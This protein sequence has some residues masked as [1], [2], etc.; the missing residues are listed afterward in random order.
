[1]SLL[2]P[3]A[4]ELYCTPIFEDV[5]KRLVDYAEEH[6]YEQT[7]ADWATAPRVWV[8]VSRRLNA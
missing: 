1:M 2:G 7:R 4:W 5:V 8:E 6:G 3:N